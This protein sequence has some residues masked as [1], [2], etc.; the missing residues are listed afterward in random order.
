MKIH[1]YLYKLLNAKWSHSDITL[2][3][4]WHIGYLLLIFGTTALIAFL[5]KGKS[6]NT[7]RKTLNFFAIAPACVY[8]LNFFM[9]PLYRSNGQIDIDKLPFHIC[10]VMG[11]V[12]V[13]AN[14]S[15]KTWLREIAASLAV[16]SSLMY[17]T[18]PGSALGGVSPFSYKV[19]ETFTFH[20]LL[21]G[22]GVLA[23]TTGHTKLQWKNI[24][25]NYI[26]L[27]FIA[28]WAMIGNVLYAGIPENHHYDW[29]F[30]TGSTFP[31]IPTWL[32]P[33]CTI[34]AVFGMVAIIY[35]IYWGFK[36]LYD[37]KHKKAETNL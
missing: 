33:I 23:L 6:E 13:F 20:G 34:G 5:L 16:V 31:F 3:S 21:F 17:M 1:S 12:I 35:L 14:F 2:F 7:K 32:M 37:K 26:A 25:Q 4:G 11:I 27:L 29:F 24:W 15:K 28:V 36:K 30:L 22:W 19:V 18:Y 10:T 8:I 9:M